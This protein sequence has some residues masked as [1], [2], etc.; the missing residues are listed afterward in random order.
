MAKLYAEMVVEKVTEELSD[1]RT[2]R[3]RWPEGYSLEFKTGQ[4]ITLC[5]PDSPV[6]R[7]AYSLSSCALDHGFF[8]VTVKR[9]GKMG[10][11]IVDWIKEGDRLGV[12]PPVGKFLPN[13]EPDH[14]LVCV[15][16][17]SGV[18]PFRAFVREATMRG[19]STGITV[20]YSVRRPVDI[21]F[22]EEFGELERRNPNFRFL[23][24]CTR[25]ES[26]DAWTGRTGRITADWLRDQVRD[27]AKT[28]FYA[29]GPTA[30]VEFTEH[31]LLHDLQIPKER[32]RLEKWG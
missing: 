16:G 22:R 32:V 21:I 30:L 6:Y 17:G 7:R 3:L 20:L 29:C 24:T 10:T 31:L 4:F 27:P 8:E 25:L 19:L 2:L 9:E 15:A 14:H 5:W 11:R 23:V 1:V 28:T 13:Y 26:G 12:L 18:T